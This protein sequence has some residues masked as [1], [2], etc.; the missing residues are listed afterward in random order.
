MVFVFSSIDTTLELRYLQIKEEILP[1]ATNIFYVVTLIICDVTNYDVINN[2]T[3]RSRQTSG[4]SGKSI[5]EHMQ[6]SKS[7]L[8]KILEILNW[9]GYL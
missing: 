1:Q 3:A 5:I 2:N 4:Q 8:S 7:I 6:V 9:L